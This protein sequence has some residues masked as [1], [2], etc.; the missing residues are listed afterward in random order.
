M[1]SVKLRSHVGKDG[2]LHLDIPVNIQEADLEVTVTF[3]PIQIAKDSSEVEDFNQLDWHEFIER[4]A[5]SCADDPIIVDNGGIDESLDDDLT[6]V[7]D[8]I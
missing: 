5:G 8:D 6:E 4:T 7:F 1:E 2:I 3:K